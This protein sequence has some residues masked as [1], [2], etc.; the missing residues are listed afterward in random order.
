MGKKAKTLHETS[1]IQ[2]DPKCRRA[3]GPN[4]Q[5]C[6]RHDILYIPH[7]EPIPVLGNNLENLVQKMEGNGSYRIPVGNNDSGSNI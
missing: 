5:L 4:S 7:D 1:Q 2:I 6:V 3:D